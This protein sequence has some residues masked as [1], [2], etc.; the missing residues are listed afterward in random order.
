MLHVR[1]SV[2]EQNFQPK[3]QSECLKTASR[4][5]NFSI[6]EDRERRDCDFCSLSSYCNSQLTSGCRWHMTNTSIRSL[7]VAKC[8]FRCL[9]LRLSSAIPN[10]VISVYK[11]SCVNVELLWMYIDLQSFK[12]LSPIPTRYIKVI[13]VR[14]NLA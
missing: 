4:M 2:K 1:V 6:E 9:K 13:S 12:H 10:Q 7:K 8:F 3:H 5:M 14:Y 11:D